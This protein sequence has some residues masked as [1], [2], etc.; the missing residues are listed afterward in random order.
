MQL[1]RVRGRL[2]TKAEFMS[3]QIPVQEFEIETTDIPDSRLQYVLNNMGLATYAKLN[4]V[5]WLGS[6]AHAHR[7]RTGDRNGQRPHR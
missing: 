4:G 7:P 2:D 5:P 6:G 1:A 3:N